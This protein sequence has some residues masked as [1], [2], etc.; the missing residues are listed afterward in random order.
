MQFSNRGL[1]DHIIKI[2]HDG[3]SQVAILVGKPIEKDLKPNG[4]GGR[5][6]TQHHAK[7]FANLVADRSTMRAVDL[8]FV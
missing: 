3:R 8:P 6:G 7:P 4:Q 5:F 1:P 2:G